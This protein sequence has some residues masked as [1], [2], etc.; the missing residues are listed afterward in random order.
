LTG[1]L[2]QKALERGKA[3]LTIIN[4]G[5]VPEMEIVGERFQTEGY[6]LPK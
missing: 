6:F 3:P 4:R 5:M 2:S 1:E